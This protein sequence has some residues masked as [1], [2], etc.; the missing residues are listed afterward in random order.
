MA[1][2]PDTLYYGRHLIPGLIAYLVTLVGTKALMPRLM[3]NGM[4]GED[5]HKPGRPLVP[6]MG[7]IAIFAGIVSGIVAAI[8]LGT[9]GEPGFVRVE[10]VT[11]ALATI[12]VV[13][14]IGIADDIIEVRQR[15]KT[16]LPAF[17]ALP[18]I[19]I[20]ANVHLIFIPG[21]GDV[22]IGLLYPLL[23]V[24][25]AVTGASNACN[26]LAGWNGL[27]AGMGVI[28]L[29]SLGLFGALAHNTT[30][31]AIA[32]PGAAACLAFLA[33]NWHPARVFPGDVGTLTI[34]GT[35]AAAVLIGQVELLGLILMVPFI[36]DFAMKMLRRLPKSFAQVQ[37]E[38]LVVPHGQAPVG[39]GQL[40]L[41]LTGGLTE[42]NLVIA[43]LAIEG[44]FAL[45]GLG[46]IWA[47]LR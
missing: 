7:G 41:H 35:F 11:G 34:G 32:L 25:L 42:R 1:T 43:L 33:F 44:V 12:A 16:L 18:L 45:L 28:L 36:M 4:V 47:M 37:G 20:L 38:K 10:F 22:D 21:I 31:I 40:V 8:A 24:P 26:M 23:V 46:L 17:A 39:M 29:G 30:I 14:V 2:G 15:A 27:E 3:R 5:V 9:F 6:E 13:A 19:A